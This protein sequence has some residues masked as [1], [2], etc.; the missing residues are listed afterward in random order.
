MGYHTEYKIWVARLP[1]INPEMRHENFEQGE[2]QYFN[3][4]TWSREKKI[5]IWNMPNWITNLHSV[6]AMERK[7][8][9]E[10]TILNEKIYK[11]V[12]FIKKIC[13]NN[14]IFCRFL[15]FNKRACF[16]YEITEFLSFNLC[17]N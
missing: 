5:I 17:D 14:L 8:V 1:N 9:W 11:C 7:S 12:I 3:K 15:N 4:D 10:R 6:T 2:Y 13:W 16:L